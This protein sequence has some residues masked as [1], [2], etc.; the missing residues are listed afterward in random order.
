MYEYDALLVLSSTY[1]NSYVIILESSE[2][3]L[4]WNSVYDLDDNA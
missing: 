2:L 3:K 4:R 1:I